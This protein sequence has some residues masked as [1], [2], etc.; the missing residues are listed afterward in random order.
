MA[1]IVKPE[2]LDTGFFEP[3]L[4]TFPRPIAA[5]QSL[6]AS[7]EKSDPRHSRRKTAASRQP[8]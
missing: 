6:P 2:I 4:K 5:C 7:A 3:I 8:A 1:Q